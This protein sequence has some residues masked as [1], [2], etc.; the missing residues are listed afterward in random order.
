MRRFEGHILAA[1]ALAAAL[2]ISADPITMASTIGPPGQGVVITINPTGT[3][4]NGT[5]TIS[6]T[7]DCSASVWT[8]FP[9]VTLGN[10]SQLSQPVGRL[11]SVNSQSFFNLT[12]DS[13]ASPVSW[14]VTFFPFSGRFSGGTAYATV[15]IS[16]CD[17][18]FNCDGGQ[19]TAV[20][21]LRGG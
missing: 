10:Y 21:K 12:F 18:A 17:Q 2:A 7:A 19:A 1:L 4:S 5:A 14:S 8:S 11:N 3:L 6:G 20:V 16:G 15:D 9:V 13:C